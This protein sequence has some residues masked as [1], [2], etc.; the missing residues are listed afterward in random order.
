MFETIGQYAEH[1][2]DKASRREFLGELGRAALL[3]ASGLAGLLALPGVA[4][5]ARKP[6]Y[7]CPG[8]SYTG[9]IGSAEGSPCFGSFGVSGTCKR[10]RKGTTCYCN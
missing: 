9:C 10:Y 5:A 1:T 2:A 4:H 7:V 6:P 3:T 8:D